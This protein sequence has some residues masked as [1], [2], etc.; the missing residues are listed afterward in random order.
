MQGQHIQKWDRTVCESFVP[1]DSKTE[2]AE[3]LRKRQSMKST[4]AKGTL[5]RRLSRKGSG[6]CKEETG[7]ESNQGEPLK[8]FLL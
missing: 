6:E 8:V 4:D 3:S 7:S 5:L 2:G 1:V